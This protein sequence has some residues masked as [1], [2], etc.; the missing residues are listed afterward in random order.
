MKRIINNRGFTIVE[1][2]VVMGVIAV[3]IG[4]SIP[5]FFTTT[6][7][8][9][10]KRSTRDVTVELKAVRQLA[11]SRNM[12][13][14][15]VFT[16]GTEDV[17]ARQFRV[18]TSSAWQDDITRADTVIDE[19]VNISSPGASFNVTFNPN[20][21]ATANTICLQN[22]S[23]STSRMKVNIYSTTGRVEASSGC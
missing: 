23:D 11:I 12:Q 22:N 20:G 7:K 10:L 17:I 21:S 5:S 1:L 4:I 9:A 8:T 15:L 13:F 14:R 6:S 2:I 16:L 3:M 19:R 18:N